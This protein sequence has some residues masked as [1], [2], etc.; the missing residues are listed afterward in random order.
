MTSFTKTLA[1]LFTVLLLAVVATNAAD[2]CLDVSVA[3]QI[4]QAYYNSIY[5]QNAVQ[6]TTA[7]QI[8]STV[9]SLRAVLSSFTSPYALDLS[10]GFSNN[11]YYS[12]QYCGTFPTLQCLSTGSEYI[13]AVVNS[14]IFGDQFTRYYSFNANGSANL[15]T[16]V[17]TD[18]TAYYPTTR[19]WFNVTGWSAPYNFLVTGTNFGSSRGYVLRSGDFRILSERVPSEPCN[20]ALS[21]SPA[22][23][24]AP[25]LT[26]NVAA[27]ST[28]ANTQDVAEN[29]AYLL[30]VL[31]TFQQG[32]SLVAVGV[33]YNT[34][35]VYNVIDCLTYGSIVPEPECRISRYI[36]QVRNTRLYGTDRAY[37]YALNADTAS[38]LQNSVFLSAARDA[39]QYITTT[40]PWYLQG[41]GWTEPYNFANGGILART[42]ASSFNGG[43]VFADSNPN[44]VFYDASQ[45][46]NVNPT[47]TPTPSPSTCITQFSHVFPI[48]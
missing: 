28:V 15:N 20:S 38:N 36:A 41:N 8:Q 45:S 34:N 30:S 33:G 43:V 2:D 23:Q 22:V 9:Q 7:A 19:P 37:I 25:Y 32:L 13:I 29:V 17:F 31:K 6:P 21:R 5:G 39:G 46:G 27:A 11:D 10:V 26:D 16:P 4:T 18:Q 24:V 42:F 47:P 3:Q 12:V 14:A 35:D 40:R 44:Q 1:L 48:E